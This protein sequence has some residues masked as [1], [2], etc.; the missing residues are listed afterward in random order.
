LQ[1]S[2][3]GNANMVA[4]KKKEKEKRKDARNLII[5]D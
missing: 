4:K 1:K 3:L 2:A 5:S